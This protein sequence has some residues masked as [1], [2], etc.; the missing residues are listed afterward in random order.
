[1]TD[2]ATII[3]LSK[4][5]DTNKSSTT[6]TTLSIVHPGVAL[7]QA[8]PCSFLS[9]VWDWLFSCPAPLFFVP[10]PGIP[11][12]CIITPINRNIAILQAIPNYS[13]FNCNV[14]SLICYS[15]H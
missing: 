2:T 13:L 11:S 6:L 10:I 3:N 5:E 8:C 14:Y 7:P 12:I 1:M 4:D 9:W 15:Q